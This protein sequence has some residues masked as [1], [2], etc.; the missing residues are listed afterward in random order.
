MGASVTLT[1][2]EPLNLLVN[3]SAE[4]GNLSGWNVT[5]SGGNGWQAGVGDPPLHLFGAMMFFT[6][7]APSTKR[8]TIDLVAAG[9]SAAELDASPPIRAREWRHGGGYTTGDKYWLT[10]EVRDANNAVL[11]SYTQ[12]TPQSPLI[13]QNAWQLAETTF[14]G[15]PAGARFVTFTDGGSD[16]EFWAGNYGVAMDA[17]SVSVGAMMMR[18]SNDGMAWSAWQPFASTA[19]WTLAAGT[20][21]RTVYV[22]YQDASGAIWSAVTD[23]IVVQ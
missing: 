11:A 14:A 19:P 4:A 2:Q 6:S 12:G 7:Y 21:T 20:G 10:I 3:P 9:Y 8:Q 17:A 5:L 22:E 13:T 23:S 18:F 1:L 16:T 15:Y